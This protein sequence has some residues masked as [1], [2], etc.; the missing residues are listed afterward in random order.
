MQASAAPLVAV[1]TPMGRQ[2]ALE[3]F[4]KKKANRC[5]VK[6]VRYQARKELA[7]QRP[8]YKGQFIKMDAQVA[9]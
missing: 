9:V 4:R 2:A 8:R 3:R 7:Q 5:F 1:S 6:K